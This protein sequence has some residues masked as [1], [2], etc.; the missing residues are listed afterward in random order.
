MADVHHLDEGTVFEALIVD[1][2]VTLPLTAALVR[3]LHFQ[4]PDGTHV[5]KPAALTT[6]GTDG[7]MQYVAEAGFL[8][9]AGV[10]A[11]QPYLE[12]A[13]GAWHGETQWFRVLENLG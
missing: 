2:T 1:G 5:L 6:D 11:W 3:E 12:F 7:K 4:R 8:N 10:W 13:A 9:Q